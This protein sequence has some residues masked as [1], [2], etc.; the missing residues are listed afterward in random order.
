M[1]DSELQQLRD[2]VATVRRIID[3]VLDEHHADRTFV[4]ACADV[5]HKR[6]E[7]LHVLEEASDLRGHYG[8][9]LP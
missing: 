4:K 7:R 3:A 9:S 8:R 1:A 6:L 5:L 2:D